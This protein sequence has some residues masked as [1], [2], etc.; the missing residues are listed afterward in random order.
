[1]D[2]TSSIC[3]ITTIDNPYNP[4]NDF[5][6]WFLFDVEQGYNTCGYLARVALTSDSL[7]DEE[8]NRIIESA[9]D[10]IIKDDPLNIYKKIKKAS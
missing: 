5:T 7:T 10:E 9:I 6:S 2:S 3:A 1:M 4:F 8:N